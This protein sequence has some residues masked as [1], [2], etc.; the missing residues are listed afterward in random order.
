MHAQ[1][2]VHG[3]RPYRMSESPVGACPGIQ[4]RYQEPHRHGPSCDATCVCEGFG[5]ETRS[6]QEGSVTSCDWG[7][8]DREAVAERRSRV[9]KEHG[10]DSVWL[11]VCSWH[12]GWDDYEGY[13]NRT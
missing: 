2:I 1:A 6:L 3:Y 10:F 11:S 13:E 8:C 4:C 9:A 7:A 5:P 12:A